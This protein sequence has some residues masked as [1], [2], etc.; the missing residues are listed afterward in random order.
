MA[1]SGKAFIVSLPPELRSSILGYLDTLSLSEFSRASK[2]CHLEAAPLL[3]KYIN[4]TQEAVETFNAEKATIYV[5]SSV[6]HVALNPRVSN[7]DEHLTIEWF[8][9]CITGLELFPNISCIEIHWPKFYP[10]SSD[11]RYDRGFPPT[12]LKVLE[13]RTIL[14]HAV[15]QNM[16]KL[17]FY[18]KTLKKLFVNFN[19]AHCFVKKLFV[20]EFPR[21]LHETIQQFLQP[22]IVAVETKVEIP[23][24]PL[25]EEAIILSIREQNR[26]REGPNA[27]ALMKGCGESLR[28]FYSCAELGYF[29]GPS[30]GEPVFPFELSIIFP[31]TK[32]LCLNFDFLQPG[33]FHGIALRF[34]NVEEFVFH[35]GP[36][37]HRPG[38]L[39]FYNDIEMIPTLKRLVLM[40][41]QGYTQLTALYEH[42]LESWVLDLATEKLSGLETVMFWRRNRNKAESA[43]Y[44]GDSSGSE[45]GEWETRSRK[46]IGKQFTLSA[47]VFTVD[48]IGSKPVIRTTR[49]FGKTLEEIIPSNIKLPNLKR[50]CV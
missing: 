47:S 38:A 22:G 24:P 5:P 33:W 15:F 29:S 36:W 34:P 40:E 9:A 19:G 32:S 16:A 44:F 3:F 41:P 42:Q 1:T 20:R 17:P 18:Q 21:N 23:S 35:R 46:K 28:A 50:A 30:S 26:F 48:R 12:D 6:R 7:N 37:K 8:R 45:S 4:L 2:T 11:G 25:L 14:F 27:F 43:S 10:S 13:F 31:K 49:T 39:S